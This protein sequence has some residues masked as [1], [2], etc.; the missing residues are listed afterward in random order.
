MFGLPEF[1]VLVSPTP[2]DSRE[3]LSPRFR[4]LRGWLKN[5]VRSTRRN[6]VRGGREDRA[7]EVVHAFDLRTVP[8]CD[9]DAYGLGTLRRVQDER[10]GW[11]EQPLDGAG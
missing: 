2:E 5:R 8:N 4:G 1:P 9:I 10:G 6:G 3:G 7:V 11:F